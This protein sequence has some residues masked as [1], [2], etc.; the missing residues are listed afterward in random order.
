MIWK[1][2]KKEF[3]LNVMTFKF[4]LGTVLCVVL[5][6]VLVPVLLEDYQQRVRDY[7]AKVTAN[8]TD[9]R[10]VKVYMNIAPTVFRPPT[11]LSVFGEG[12]ETRLANA[13][14]IELESIPEVNSTSSETNPYL[15]IFP[16]LDVTLIFKIVIGILALLMAY[17]V[18][19]G[20]AQRGTLKLTLSNTIARPHV[21][22]GKLLGGLLT[23]TV[24]ITITFVVGL[25]ILGLSPAVSLTLADWARIGLMYVTSLIFICTMFSLGLL[26]STLARKS[27]T[28]LIL[29]L[30]CWIV[31][32]VV[33]PSASIS[34]AANARIL[35]PREKVAGRLAALQDGEFGYGPGALGHNRD[36]FGREYV[37]WLTK[38][39]AEHTQKRYAFY[40]SLS[41]AYA[42]RLWEVERGH[43]FDVL[44]QK[45]LT[46]T[47]ARISPLSLYEN[48]MS[49]LS[50]TDLVTARSFMERARA[51]RNEVI[52]Y[53]RSQTDD[54]RLPSYFTTMSMDEM[55]E[56]EQARAESAIERANKIRRDAGN[57]P[58]VVDLRGFPTFGY[59]PPGI[60]RSLKYAAPDLVLLMLNNFLFLALSFVAFLRYDVR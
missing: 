44:K 55:A 46:D 25:L 29:A 30:L 3:L 41:M 35:E 2:A 51:Y 4:A 8:E 39:V 56:I 40:R 31:Y 47:L 5:V 36:A 53:I 49:S 1:I 27:A 15:S 45:S 14:K 23:L 28:C 17:D 59:E 9:L 20:E 21:L 60:I 26:V 12:Y 22:L 13:A 42:D 58:S 33:V 10:E 54:F 16:V 50:G 34:V 43:L 11:I 52:E 48:V 7:S 38:S 32:A 37:L 24:P 57:K 18:V 19:S 6:A